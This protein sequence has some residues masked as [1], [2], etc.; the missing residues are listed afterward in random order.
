MKELI[1]NAESRGYI[2]AAE[3]AENKDTVK[4]KQAL[5]RS[6]NDILISIQLPL[7]REKAALIETHATQLAAV[8]DVEEKAKLQLS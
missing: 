2:T 3:I 4:I 6:T 7:R 1:E 5:A 8:T